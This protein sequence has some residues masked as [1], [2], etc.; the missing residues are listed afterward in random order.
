MKGLKISWPLGQVKTVFAKKKTR[1][2]AGK[3]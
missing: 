2:M 1:H 3:N